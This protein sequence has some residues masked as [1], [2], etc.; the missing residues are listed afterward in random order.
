MNGQG[1]MKEFEMAC[2]ALCGQFSSR[3]PDIKKAEQYILDAKRS[4]KP[5][6]TCVAIAR[7]TKNVHVASHA[8]SIISAAVLREW[9]ELSSQSGG[10]TI[11]AIRNEL[12]KMGA[13]PPQG[14]VLGHNAVQ[15]QLAHV[16]AVISKRGWLQSESASAKATLEQIST[17]LKASKKLHTQRL[18]LLLSSAMIE[19]IASN[20]STALEL[21]MEFHCKVR[22]S[23]QNKCLV[24]LFGLLAGLLQSEV[25]GGGATKN[26]GQLLAP[27]LQ[28]MLQILSFPFCSSTDFQS[29]LKKWTAMALS[30]DGGDDEH[31]YLTPGNEW[32]PL[33]INPKLLD[34][35]F[36]LACNQK[37][38]AS[39]NTAHLVRE[40]LRL[41]ASLSGT[42]LPAREAKI[43]SEYANK[44]LHGTLKMATAISFKSPNVGSHVLDLCRIIRRLITNFTFRTLVTTHPRSAQSLLQFLGQISC[45]LLD[46]GVNSSEDGVETWHSEAFDQILEIWGIILSEVRVLKRDVASSSSAK[47]RSSHFN[48]AKKGDKPSLSEGQVSGL[49]KFMKECSE[50]VMAHYIKSKMAE[51]TKETKRG[52]EREEQFLDNLDE[53]LSS[54][55]MLG[56]AAA[57]PTL[58][59]LS[60]II[61]AKTQLLAAA[62]NSKSSSSSASSASSSFTSQQLFQIREAQEQLFWAL[63]ILG[64]V[65]A[66]E[67]DGE[68]YSMHGRI[69]AGYPGVAEKTADML[70]GLAKMP[71]IRQSIG[72]TKGWMLLL[73]AYSKQ[74]ERIVGL[75]PSALSKLTKAICL[76]IAE[77]I[78]DEPQKQ[79]RVFSMVVAPIRDILHSVLGHSK[80]KEN[81]YSSGFIR[82]LHIALSM[83]HGV[84]RTEGRKSCQLSHAFL[85]THFEAIAKLVGEYGAREE[86]RYVVSKAVEFFVDTVESHLAYCTSQQA[87]FLIRQSLVVVQSYTRHF[88]RAAAAAEGEAK[89]AAKSPHDSRSPEEEEEEESKDE[90]D[91]LNLIKLLSN[92]TTSNLDDISE[93]TRS[94]ALDAVLQGCIEP[95]FLSIPLAFFLEEFW[96][97]VV[98]CTILPPETATKVCVRS[99]CF[100]TVS[101]N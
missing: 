73:E 8:I 14:S 11:E 84:G 29:A 97:S 72:K 94:Q 59:R 89:S 55:A 70:Y 20:R 22:F 17:L 45:S 63:K 1:V 28:V 39:E 92:L 85:G 5:Y 3:F 9:N 27:L 58:N 77:G 98:A 2:A 21:S 37:V 24:T 40:N 13:Q 82:R 68:A 66:D 71:K 91:V 54:V 50:K 100:S 16:V 31:R 53:H 36:A 61:R 25:E 15:K 86:G 93:G 90:E 33:L 80:F 32:R 47:R 83:L 6:K 78:V 67:A 7:G 64:H 51:A 48:T 95:F 65:M 75:Q 43:R 38:L 56:R 46:V 79:R 74:H 44:M 35:L 18:G 52:Y 81:K 99:S 23:F 19:E 87:L 101:Y 60:E 30:S 41:M 49:D 57:G 10:G 62:A 42:V 4:P 34:L 76:S 88:T 12:L 96:E 26:N 69:P